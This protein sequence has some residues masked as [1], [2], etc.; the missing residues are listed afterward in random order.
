[1]SLSV[2]D[3]ANRRLT[4]CSAGHLPIM[5]KRR[6]GRVEEFGPDVSGFPLGIDVDCKY[7]Q[8]TIALEP[9]EVAVIYTDGV[10]DAR[11]PSDEAYDT[12]KNHRLRKRITDI[13]GGPTAIGKAILQELREFSAGQPQFDDI[14]VVCFGPKA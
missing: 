9:G 1:M 14:T 6:D 2:L 11:S 13:S 12:E 5:V 10:C 7:D 4:Y 3:H 8:A